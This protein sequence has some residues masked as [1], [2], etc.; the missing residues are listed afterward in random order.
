MKKLL[1]LAILV[2]A[3]TSCSTSDDGADC[4]CSK[5]YYSFSNNDPGT[6]VNSEDVGCVDEVG[7]T[8]ID[9]DTFF[10]IECN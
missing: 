5:N 6:L 8:Y 1:I 2:I 3:F 4:N 9:S 10:R 7:T